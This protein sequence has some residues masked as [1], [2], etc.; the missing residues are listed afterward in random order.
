L[1]VTVIVTNTKFKVIPLH[2][3]LLYLFQVNPFSTVI[4]F[5]IAHFFK[6]I[7]ILLFLSLRNVRTS[8]TVFRG[9]D[10]FRFLF[11]NNF[12]LPPTFAHEREYQLWQILSLSLTWSFLL[13]LYWV[14]KTTS[15]LDLVSIQLLTC[16]G[17]WSAD[18]AQM[19][20]FDQKRF[21]FLLWS[22]DG[23]AT[24]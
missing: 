13:I 15:K 6:A 24:C 20:D 4:H 8:W 19:R 5:W 10:S 16:V 22:L 21:S 14:R 17:E 7:L 11:A 1:I 3:L 12:F 18:E 23:M 2:S 9:P